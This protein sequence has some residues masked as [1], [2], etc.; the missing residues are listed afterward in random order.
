V[1]YRYGTAAP[2]SS[3][4]LVPVSFRWSASL[5]AFVLRHALRY[6]GRRG[7]GE[8]RLAEIET[9]VVRWR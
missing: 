1:E 7:L 4:D 3:D 2:W 9:R 8:A 5:E 6:I